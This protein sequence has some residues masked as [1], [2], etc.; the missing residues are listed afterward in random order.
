MARSLDELRAA[1]INHERAAGRVEAF[2]GRHTGRLAE[3]A[4]FLQEHGE[5]KP[6]DAAMAK[7]YLG[8]LADRTAQLSEALA[9][10]TRIAGQQAEVADDL[11][12]ASGSMHRIYAKAS[13]DDGDTPGLEAL[14]GELDGYRTLSREASG[15]ES[16]IE[17]DREELGKVGESELAE[18][19]SA[20]L[21]R[22]VHSL[23][24]ESD[25]ADERRRAIADI[26]AEVREARRGSGLQELIAGREAARTKLRE[27]R[28]EAILA[29]A[30][31][32][33]IDTVEREY[34]QT[35]MPRVFERAHGH[36]SAFTHHGYELRLGGG[37][38]SPRL[39]AIDL[40][41]GESRELAELSD[42][43]RGQ[44]LLAARMAFA[45]EVE[46]GL[47][48]PLFL[49]E[50]LDQSDPARF[51]AIAG[52]LG[53]MA[54]DQGRQVFYLTSDPLDRERVGSALEKEACAIASEIDL[55]EVRRRSGIGVRDPSELRVPPR[56]S[57]PEPDAMTAEEYGNLL[58]VPPFS[59]GRG[60]SHQ[61]LFYLVPD[62]LGLLRAL[63]D[64]GIDGAGQWRTFARSPLAARLA[65][66]SAT[67]KEIG[68]RVS[69][70]QVFCEAWSQGRGRAVGRDALAASGAV[71]ERFL[72][73]VIAVAGELEGNPDRL[74]TALRSRKKVDERLKGFRG[75][76]ANALEEYL[77]DGGYLDDRTVLD[78][79]GVRLRVLASPPVSELP[80]G[81]ASACIGR[82]WAWAAARSGAGP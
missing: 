40:R 13:L 48:L 1:R 24:A 74:L 2:Q 16:Q 18:L 35:Q 50:A 57:V 66:R 68:A 32:F 34:E 15:L 78:E 29:E 11:D 6:E 26:D 21:D 49:D 5:R 77:R 80:D 73:D 64:N 4:D 31:R 42:G 71:T 55:G 52:S 22:L 27:R 10:E 17:L 37:T 54:K 14:V 38:R 33:L 67:A 46:R 36:F 60:Y 41:S 59:P 45:E 61:H 65:S 20:E 8:R 39:F 43:T 51:A 23:S 53:R 28:D 58:G 9:A 63:L 62:D 44:L 47:T 12:K 30:G 25:R 19:E 70:L 69:L 81:V 76:A 75:K 82:W 3:L 79:E 7:A 56:P 72:D